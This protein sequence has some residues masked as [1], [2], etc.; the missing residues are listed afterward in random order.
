MSKYQIGQRFLTPSKQIVLLLN[1]TSYDDDWYCSVIDHDSNGQ[2]T[3]HF[4]DFNRMQLETF[5]RMFEG[6]TEFLAK[7]RHE[8]SKRTLSDPEVLKDVSFN[9]PRW[10]KSF[11]VDE[12]GVLRCFSVDKS[13][14]LLIEQQGLPLLWDSDT[15][16]NNKVLDDGYSFDNGK[17]VYNSPIYEGHYEVRDHQE[18]LDHLAFA[19]EKIFKP[20]PDFLTT[21]NIFNENPDNNDYISLFIN[22]NFQSISYHQG[23]ATSVSQ[24]LTPLM[25]KQLIDALTDPIWEQ[26]K[27]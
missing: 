17:A 1:P 25:R 5:I 19:N 2:P 6:E 8:Q 18:I 7:R 15:P 9:A 16:C 12:I 21:F 14:L 10:A 3:A 26:T 23:F 27:K 22:K 20:N 13:H 4:S 24:R 11:A